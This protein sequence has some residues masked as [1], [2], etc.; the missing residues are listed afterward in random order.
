MEFRTVIP[1][2]LSS[3]PIERGQKILAFGSCFAENIGAYLIR[4]KFDIDLN[5][6]GILYNPLSVASPLR[7]LDERRLFGEADLFR[8][9]NQWH[10]FSHHSRFSHPDLHTCLDNINRRIVQSADTLRCAD[11]LLITW[12]TAWVYRLKETG[13][14]VSNCHKLPASV[15]SRERLTPEEIVNV[16]QPL[17]AGLLQQNP[18][19]RIC[20]TVSPIRHFRDGAHGNQL[21]KS[22]LLLA[23]DRL[24]RSFPENCFYFPS[25]EI[26]M[27]EL[28]DYRF[29]DTDMVHPSE[30][31]VAYL[32]ERFGQC[33]FSDR[34][35]R[36]NEEWEKMLKLLSHRPLSADA[37]ACKNFAARTLDK[38]HEFQQKYSTFDVSS[39]LESLSSFMKNL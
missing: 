16:W 12:G 15:F 4:Y 27:D 5:P 2:E 26:V 38:L 14:V 1:V 11:W 17:I 36:E 25:Y 33:Y 29:Y 9:E 39:E 3:F 18:S 8:Q 22:I 31:A 21:S 28:R 6:F 19:L 34:T 23:T 13:D 37:A 10:S 35:R 7:I 32:W 24:C 30:Q 20:F